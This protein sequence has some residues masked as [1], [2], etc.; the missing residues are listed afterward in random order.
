LKVCLFSRNNPYRTA[1]G[2]ETYLLYLTRY[3]TKWG[4]EVVLAYPAFPRN[5]VVKSTI[6]ATLKTL[7]IDVGEIYDSFQLASIVKKIHADIYHGQ[8]QHGFG[9]GALRRVGIMS[10][11]P[12]VSTA[13]GSAWGMMQNSPWSNTHTKLLTLRMEKAAFNASNEVICVS[14]STKY[15]LTEGYGVKSN[16]MHV[17]NNGV[18]PNN[19]VKRVTKRELHG[20]P[21][22]F[23]V[24]FFARGGARKGVRTSRRVLEMLQRKLEPKQEIA[25][26][27]IV[28]KESFGH[29]A[30]ICQSKDCVLYE[31]PSNALL[32]KLL[33][34]SDVFVFPTQYEGHS[35]SLL[36]AMAARNVVL[37]SSIPANT[38]TVENG[39]SGY[40]LDPASKDAWVYRILNLYSDQKITRRIQENAFKRVRDHFSAEVMCQKTLALYESMLQVHQDT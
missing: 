28:D 26:Q 30:P 11:K 5:R 35:F 17:I 8:A 24:T 22:Q 38:E 31:C 15:E 3:F 34:A 39:V 14:K 19:L 16:Q 20:S 21:D 4:H 37:T 33:S 36:E 23:V 18:D 7:R 12:F 29:F 25:I 27:V 32:P 40:A 1:G 6:W 10:R 2:I 9:F 13:H